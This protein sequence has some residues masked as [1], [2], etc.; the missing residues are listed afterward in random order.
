VGKQAANGWFADCCLDTVTRPLTHTLGYALRGVL[1]A[2]LVSG[3]AHLLKHAESTASALLAQLRGDGWLA[4]RFDS[5]WRPCVDWCCLTGSVQ[6][7]HCW[8]ILANE[9]NEDRYIDGARRLNAFVRRTLVQNGNADHIGGI[10]GSW[11]VYGDYGR[12]EFLNWAAKFFIDSNRAE[13]A[14]AD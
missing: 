4:G 2:H 3:E 5:D 8:L 10:R 12:Y 7:A 1:E 13:M 14:L 11:P 6:I 9:T